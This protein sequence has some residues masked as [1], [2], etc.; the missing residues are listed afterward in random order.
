MKG[1]SKR[2]G[3]QTLVVIEFL[4]IVLV[5]KHYVPN[6]D[7]NIRV[8]AGG[9]AL[10]RRSSRG[11]L[12]C[13][14]GG[15]GESRIATSVQDL[16]CSLA[17]LKET[18]TPRLVYQILYGNVFTFRNYLSIMSVYKILEPYRII[19][20]VPAEFKPKPEEY[21]MWF[22]KAADIIPYLETRKYSDDFGEV[23]GIRELRHIG[24]TEL[25]K[26]GGIY[27]NLNTI[28]NTDLWKYRAG[29]I[30]V[31]MAGS[32]YLGFVQVAR[33][34]NF[35]EFVH[36]ITGFDDFSVESYTTKC[37]LPHTFKDY[38]HCCIISHVIYPMNIMQSVSHFASF[39]RFLFYG[40][41]KIPLPQPTYPPIPKIVHYVWFGNEHMTYSMYLS[42]QSTLRFVKPL[43]IIIYVE[44]Y[45]LGHYF[46]AMKNSSVVTVVIDYGRP[47]FVFQRPINKFSHLSDYVRADVLLRLGGIYI[48]WD[49]FWLKPVDDLLNLGY[50]T[51]A[52]VDPVIDILGRQDFPDLINMG[53][54]LARPGSKFVALWMDSFHKYIGDHATFHAVEMVYKLYE[55]HPD[56]IYLEERLQV[57]CFPYKTCHPLWLPDYQKGKV[58]N[59]FDFTKD[60]YSVHITG[61][62]PTAFKSEKGM[63]TSAEDFFTDMARHINGVSLSL[64]NEQRRE[65]TGLRISDQV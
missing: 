1:F 33:N 28:I 31:G 57:L 46:D 3:L 15:A 18:H 61:P 4:I 41:S 35:T 17:E 26:T 36:N 13:P 5:V 6:V 54:L 32:S 34:F 7:L 29:N 45:D 8:R 52:S 59:E 38:E 12:D 55:D 11:S 37:V 19:L 60:A 23:D 20:Y 40:T 49:V 16:N 43:Q 53:V 24:A 51:I 21:N 14:I 39:A 22:Q 48:D 10:D 9:N 62:L 27:V 25:R 42:F 47:R 30:R 50:E 64:I 65:K 2:Y 58:H 63:M 44:S 56:L